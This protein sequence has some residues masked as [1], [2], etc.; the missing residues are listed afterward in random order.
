MHTLSIP[1]TNKLGDV[2]AYA[3]QQAIASLLSKMGKYNAAIIPL[4]LFDLEVLI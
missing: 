4:P 2:Y 1:V 3:D